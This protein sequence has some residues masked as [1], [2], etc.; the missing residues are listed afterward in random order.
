MV[1]VEICDAGRRAN[2]GGTVSSRY[3]EGGFVNVLI[4]NAVH[5]CFHLG[6]PHY[7]GPSLRTALGL[8]GRGGGNAPR[9]PEW[10]IL[11]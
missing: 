6:E 8:R 1:P 5:S 2:S 9:A 7:R 11:H 10:G 4:A 3:V